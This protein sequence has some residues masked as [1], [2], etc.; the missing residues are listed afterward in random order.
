[1]ETV[2]DFIFL[3]S[4]ITVDSDCSHE[5][6]R[7]LLLGWKALTN[8]GSML[9]SRD[10]TSQTEVGIVKAVVFSVVTYRCE[11]WTIKRVS[12]EELMLLNCRALESP[13]DWKEIK[14]VY[15]KGNQP[16]KFIGRTDAEAE[17]PI[18]WPPKG[19]GWLIGKDLVPGK[20][21]G[22][23]DKRAQRIKWLD[24][25]INSVDIS[26]SKTA[27]DSEGQGRLLCCSSWDDKDLDM[28][29]WLNN[30][31]FLLSFNL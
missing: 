26:L 13:L 16:W 22:Q 1:M 17:A 3:G 29:E 4:K 25:I 23:E 9:K 24:G 5:I 10:I 28:T 21:W 20:D 8:L 27:G 2:T 14:Q 19:K 12:T 6:K 30:K 31:I 11:S 18:L 15:P 7:H